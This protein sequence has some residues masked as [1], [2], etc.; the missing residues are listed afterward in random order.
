M[1]QNPS[2]CVMR[3]NPKINCG[4]QMLIMYR[5]L[6]KCNRDHTSA[7]LLIIR[8]TAWRWWRGI[9]ELS[10]LS[11][12]TFYKPETALETKPIKRKDH[13]V[14]C[15][16]YLKMRLIINALC[17]YSLIQ[18]QLNTKHWNIVY[19]KFRRNCGRKCSW[20]TPYPSSPCT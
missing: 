19:S 3:E 6:F 13:I 17:I 1:C 18:G 7:R 10:V 12:Q 5:Y 15:L 2:N 20:P 16:V 4:L 9:Q 8:E 14:N 11:V